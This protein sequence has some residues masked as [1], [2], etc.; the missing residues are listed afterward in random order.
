MVF[1]CIYNRVVL[2][3]GSVLIAK[4]HHK[5]VIYLCI[6][7]CGSNYVY[8]KEKNASGAFINGAAATICS[9]KKK[10]ARPVTFIQEWWWLGQP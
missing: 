9:G 4:F 6:F 7:K 8:L 2:I 1:V 10:D 5:R 3:M